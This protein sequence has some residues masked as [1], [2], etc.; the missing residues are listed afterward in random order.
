MFGAGELPVYPV[1]RSA[2]ARSDEMGPLLTVVLLVVF[3]AAIIGFVVALSSGM[4]NVAL[5]IALFSTAFLARA[6]CLKRR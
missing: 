2:R 3:I 1:H 4:T 5:I 6:D